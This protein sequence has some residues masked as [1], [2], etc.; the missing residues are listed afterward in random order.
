MLE[1]I[2]NDNSSLKFK[3]SLSLEEVEQLRKEEYGKIKKDVNIKGFR[4]GKVPIQ[5]AERIFKKDIIYGRRLRDEFV[6]QVYANGDRIFQYIDFKVNDDLS[7]DC[8]LYP[9]Q[10]VEFKSDISNL[11]V[12]KV[13]HEVT[14]EEIEALKKSYWRQCSVKI[15]RTLE[16]QV[17][18]DDDVV[19]DFIIKLKNEIINKKEDYTFNLGLYLLDEN[20]EKNLIGI[21]AGEQKNFSLDINGEIYE[22]DI[23]CKKIYQYQLISEEEFLKKLNVKSMQQLEDNIK[24]N[25]LMRKQSK[26][27]KGELDELCNQLAVVSDFVMPENM[28]EELTKNSKSD[29]EKKMLKKMYEDNFRQD[30]LLYS[31]IKALNI[32]IT[33]EELEERNV[34]MKKMKKKNEDDKLFKISLKDN[35]LKEKIKKMMIIDNTQKE[36]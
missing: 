6:K 15:E 27:Y 35:M 3:F 25:L 36:K 9:Y 19:V 23:T 7:V 8:V 26:G 4:K 10:E 14:K 17:S 12:V 11:K 22:Y 18:E 31:A 21:K 33:D 16:Y 34:Q 28:G 29:V 1:K 32:V 20:L 5:I 13:N 24:T 2:K 30:S